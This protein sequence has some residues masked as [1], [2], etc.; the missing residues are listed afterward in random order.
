MDRLPPKL[1]I[2]GLTTKS[3]KIRALAQAGYSRVEIANFLGVIYQ[4]VR[5]VLVQAGIEAEARNDLR[6][7]S[8]KPSA[9]A[10]ELWPIDRLLDAGFELLGSCEATGPDVFRY[11]NQA[12]AEPGVYAFGVDGSVM[13]IGLTRGA[14]RT[15]LGH[16]I[17]GHEKQATSARVKALILEALANERSV[18]VC[19]AR[20]PKLDWNG[21][22]VDGSAGLETGLI[23]LISPP[24]NQQ[25]TS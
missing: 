23:K 11:S 19:I 8:R 16:Y 1:V 21:L 3:A 12:P 2:E 17:Y 20:P 14:L 25:G 13:Y 15:R 10:A 24:W 4:H 22:P 9:S 7:S 18:Q 6:K 5:N